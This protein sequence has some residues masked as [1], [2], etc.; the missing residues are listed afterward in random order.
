MPPPASEETSEPERR[1][2]LRLPLWAGITAVGVVALAGAAA[3]VG[4][5]LGLQETECA[6]VGYSSLL[7]VTLAGEP[8]SVAHVQ[9]REGDAWQPPFPAGPDATPPAIT[10]SRDGDTWT[11]TLFYPANPVALRALDDDGGVLARTERDVGWERVGGTEECGGPTEGHV[12][13]VL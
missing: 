6:A 3:I 8:S 4:P 9:V 7:V 10:T 1:R 13:W 2:P 12:D 11:F 5:R